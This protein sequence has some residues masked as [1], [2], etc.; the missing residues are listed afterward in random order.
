MPYYSQGADPAIAQGI[1]NLAGAL[2][3]SGGQRAQMDYMMAQASEANARRTRADH[4]F[5]AAQTLG[6]AVASGEDPRQVA[7]H[8]L[9]TGDP[10]MIKQLGPTLR[11]IV[12][13]NPG[14]DEATARRFQFGAG[15]NPGTDFALTTGRADQLLDNA[16]QRDLEQDSQAQAARYRRETDLANMKSQNWRPNT[17]EEALVNGLSVPG[18]SDAADFMH[19]RYGKV[20]PDGSPPAT[21]AGDLSHDKKLRAAKYLDELAGTVNSLVDQMAHEGAPFSPEDR[22]RLVQGAMARMRASDF[23]LSPDEAVYQTAQE[24]GGIKTEG[25]WNPFKTNRSRLGVADAVAPS[26]SGVAPSPQPGAAPLPTQIVAPD[27]RKFSQQDILETAAK[28]GKTPEEVW[29]DMRANG[30]EEL[31]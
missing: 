7:A 23:A 11:S 3:P 6:D 5:R 18:V 14:L 1:N 2:F 13:L 17:V 16:H 28:Y 10:D 31:Y 4:A 30:F 9:R 26:P 15:D 20:T 19:R 22:G 12:S 24:L 8:M 27:G 21:G 25:E 29:E